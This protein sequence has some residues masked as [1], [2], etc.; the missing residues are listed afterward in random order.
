M[1]FWWCWCCHKEEVFFGNMRNFPPH[2]VRVVYSKA[3][4]SVK[5]Y[6]KELID[7][8]S[9]MMCS[10]GNYDYY[11]NQF[12]FTFFY[13]LWDPELAILFWKYSVIYFQVVLKLRVPIDRW[14][15]DP[16]RNVV[17]YPL[18]FTSSVYPSVCPRRYIFQWKIETNDFVFLIL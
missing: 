5:F 9:T 7:F 18:W 16:K 17:R 13:R 3:G 14:I 8:E 2:T 10:V 12:V 15:W 6:W 4:C 1:P 11:I